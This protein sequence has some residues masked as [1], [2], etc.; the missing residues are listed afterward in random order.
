M[1][2]QLDDYVQGFMDVYGRIIQSRQ[3]DI[4]AVRL[5]IGYVKVEQV[6]EAEENAT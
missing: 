3:I 4:F 6:K 2:K 1:Q 5:F